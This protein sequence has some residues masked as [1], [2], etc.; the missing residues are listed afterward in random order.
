MCRMISSDCWLGALGM[1]RI[2]ER[3]MYQL[4]DVCSAIWSNGL[5]EADCAVCGSMD[6]MDGVL[7]SQPLGMQQIGRKYS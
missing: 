1:R 6:A 7:C 4:A 5:H 3:D 2:C